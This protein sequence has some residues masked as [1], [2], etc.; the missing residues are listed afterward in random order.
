MKPEDADFKQLHVGDSTF[1]H[2]PP[3]TRW[4]IAG[5]IVIVLTVLIIPMITNRF[6]RITILI[7]NPLARGVVVLLDMVANK[8]RH[9]GR[10]CSC[11]HR[12]LQ[13]VEFVLL[14]LT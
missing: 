10:N 11:H 2:C 3:L 14:C 1:I 13:L 12:V 5:E 8:L 6:L 4:S 9:S 7:L